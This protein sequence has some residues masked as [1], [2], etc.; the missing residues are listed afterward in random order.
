MIFGSPFSFLAPVYSGWGDPRTYRGAGK[1]HH[2]IDL[3]VPVGTPVL[4]IAPGT[5]V[6]AH[7]DPCN[8][9]G[10]HVIIL[11]DDQTWRSEYL[12]LDRVDVQNGQHVSQG[13]QIGLA[14]KTGGSM[15][16]PGCTFGETKSHLHLFVTRHVSKLNQYRIYD[17]DAR[18]HVK[19]GGQFHSVPAEPLVPALYSARV[20]S[21]LLLLGL[22]PATLTPTQKASGVVIAVGG[23]A[24]LVWVVLLRKRAKELNAV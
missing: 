9:A 3:F 20:L 6:F 13:Q 1:T 8:T 18:P 11:H 14:G 7:N 23:I 17:L 5:V 4:S 16:G 22:T 12:H 15:K 21:K 19:E 24:F 10:K 2:G